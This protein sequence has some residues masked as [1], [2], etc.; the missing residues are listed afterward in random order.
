MKST[1]RNLFTKN[2]ILAIGLFVFLGSIIIP[3][4]AADRFID[5]GDGTVTDTKT[6][7]VWAAKD[8][9]E[10][11]N[12]AEAHSYCQGYNGGGHKDWRM[13]TLVELKTLYDPE[14]ENTG[15][16][17]IPSAI[18]T[19]AESCWASDTRGDIAARFNFTHGREYW[20]RKTHSGVGRVLPV[21]NGN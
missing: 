3:A 20:L 14:I 15:G 8:N 19:T 18:D 13:P 17:H 6:G 1:T 16:Y 4:I 9:G 7:L 12:W 5:N 10:I 11:I 2:I 21:R